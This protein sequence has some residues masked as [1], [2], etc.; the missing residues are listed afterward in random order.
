M[1]IK[2]LFVGNYDIAVHNIRPEA[3]A[4]IGLKRAGV[5]VEVMTKADCWYA[6]RM[7]EFG[8]GI[9]DFMPARKFSLD[10]I[11]RMR[12]VLREGGDR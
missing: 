5:D 3:E 7:R 12:A 1:S 6:G 11:R 2:V 8:I 4:I 9:H 10:A